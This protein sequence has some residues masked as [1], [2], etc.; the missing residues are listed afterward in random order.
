MER[1]ITRL[2][3][4]RKTALDFTRGAAASPP[5]WWIAL[6]FLIIVVLWVPFR[7]SSIASTWMLWGA[8]IWPWSAGPPVQLPIGDVFTAIGLAAAV[9]AVHLLFP[10]GEA[11]ALLAANRHAQAV[12][13]TLLLALVIAVPAEQQAF[14]YF[15]F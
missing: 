12:I 8:M 7:A 10:R 11:D 2:N 13:A 15:Q 5:T 3:A 1:R 9:F 4:L 14:I 6:T